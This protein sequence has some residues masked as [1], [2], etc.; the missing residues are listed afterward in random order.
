VE[1]KP[2][3]E[4]PPVI[5]RMAVGDTVQD[6]LDV[7]PIV[8][9]VY[10]HLAFTRP[11]VD[12]LVAAVRRSG[13]TG[14]VRVIGPNELLA[15][16]LITLGYDVDLWVLNGLPLS[17]EVIAGAS[18]RGSLEDVLGAPADKLADVIV[19][20]YI[21]EAAALAP[22]ELLKVLKAGLREAG[23]LIVACRQPRELRHRLYGVLRAMNAV[24]PEESVLP[25]SPTWPALP[26]RR[27]LTSRDL[28]VAAAGLFSVTRS[29]LVNDHRACMT[30]E[31]LSLWKW[32][33]KEALHAAKQAVPGFRDCALV[34]LVSSTST[35]APAPRSA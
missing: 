27:L 3:L 12:A 1:S 34:T 23:T 22:V 25:P 11:L 24:G 19:A 33:A 2:A 14:R 13:P 7:L 6:L 5:H 4:V 9:S 20:P 31:A 28:T 15:Q 16:A 26:A 21:A 17:E 18:R 30:S 8:D 35:T 29:E 32:I 10:H